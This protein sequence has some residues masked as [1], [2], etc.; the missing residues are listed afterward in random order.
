[1]KP[2]LFETLFLWEVE[3]IHPAPGR[4]LTTLSVATKER[5]FAAAIEQAAAIVQNIPDMHGR[6]YPFPRHE[7]RA[8]RCLGG[9]HRFPGVE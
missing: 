8:V 1:M 6:H 7:V 3:Y 4:G 9:L 5:R 2:P